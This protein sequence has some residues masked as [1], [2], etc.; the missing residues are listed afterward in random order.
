MKSHSHVYWVG[1][2]NPTIKRATLETATAESLRLS[3]QHPGE[4]FEI[5]ECLGV[6]RTTTTTITLWDDGEPEAE[7]PWIDHD[8]G[9]MP[10]KAGQKIEIMFRS[11]VTATTRLPERWRWEDFGTHADIIKWRPVS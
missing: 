4:V 8:G 10:C 7:T 6:S 11:K 1:Y 9:E 2:S 5:L 3:A